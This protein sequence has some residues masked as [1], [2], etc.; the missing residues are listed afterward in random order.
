MPKILI[1]ED[2]FYINDLM[3]KSLTLTGNTRFSA[4][5]GMD[6]LKLIQSE[7]PDLIILDVIPKC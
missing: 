4:Y 2:E 3:K 6:A 1:V 5:D 7:C